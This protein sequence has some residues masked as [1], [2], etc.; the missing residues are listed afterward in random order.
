MADYLDNHL[1]EIT[2]AQLAN[3]TFYLFG[4]TFGSRWE[5]LYN[6]YPIPEEAAG[7]DPVRA[8]G[9]GGKYSGVSFHTH[10]AAWG[11]TLHGRKRWFLWPP[12]PPPPFQPNITMLQWTRRT[13]PGLQRA[14]CGSADS[15]AVSLTSDGTLDGSLAGDDLFDCPG[16]P[17]YDVVANV[18]DILY[19]PPGW[20]HATLNLDPYT[21]FFS[22]FT[23]ETLQP[24]LDDPVG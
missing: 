15:N 13:L 10:G 21:V 5:G 6:T 1:G 20:W 24:T 4:D 8:F 22:V 7:D 14:V 16:G 17:L 18:G 12:G 11:E 9:I 23:K 2:E 19:I 3:E